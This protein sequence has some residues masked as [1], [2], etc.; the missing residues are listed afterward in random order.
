MATIY[1]SY[2]G[3]WALVLAPL[4]PG[5]DA[6]TVGSD[7]GADP[8]ASAQDG[9]WV[10][11]SAAATTEAAP[12]PE[13]C[14]GLDNNG[15]GQVDEGCACTP[16]STQQCY[17]GQP[18]LAGV[19]RCARGS[20]QCVTSAS[21]NEFGAWGPCTGSVM[22]APE[23]CGNGVD[24]DCDGKDLACPPDISP[25]NSTV[26]FKAGNSCN[27]GFVTG[28]LLCAKT[29]GK[30]LNIFNCPM[31]GKTKFFYVSSPS[32]CPK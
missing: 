14:D 26:F 22:P 6:A 15:D 23:V 32:S 2:W 31:I 29:P 24:E 16:G 5:C 10:S 11:D 12:G 20:Q 25:T 28:H 4:V 3:L 9:G 13:Q 7:P 19:G 27:L 30:G 8:Q 18:A 21:S 1:R 17:A